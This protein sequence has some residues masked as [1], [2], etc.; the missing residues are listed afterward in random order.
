MKKTLILSIT[1][2]VVVIIAILTVS[3]FAITDNSGRSNNKDLKEEKEET[4][5]TEE[6]EE[7]KEE[8]AEQE[9]DDNKQDV[10]LTEEQLQQLE[11]IHLGDATFCREEMIIRG[12]LPK[13]AP[14]LT[15]E[16]AK[17]ILAKNAGDDLTL[18]YIT[19]YEMG[20]V[21]D[22]NYG[23]G[24][25]YTEFWLDDQ[26]HEAI[27]VADCAFG[28]SYDVFNSDGEKLVATVK[29]VLYRIPDDY[30]GHSYSLPLNYRLL[31]GDND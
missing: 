9:K 10:P 29:D 14:R 19:L 3:V 27:V 26:G 31:S 2:I 7:K 1:A 4:E 22:L 17:E 24:L 16:L 21:P 30:I 11:K 23:C 8:A 6:K 15:I 28:V 5:E 13:N 12:E 25:S 18:F 20:I